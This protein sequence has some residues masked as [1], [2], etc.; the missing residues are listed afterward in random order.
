MKLGQNEAESRRIARFQ[1]LSRGRLAPPLGDAKIGDSLVQLNRPDLLPM[2]G[3]H[4][5]VSLDISDDAAGVVPDLNAPP[6]AGL[7]RRSLRIER[8]Q[9]LLLYLRKNYAR[10]KSVPHSV[11][12]G[13]V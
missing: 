5:A 3:R 12:K 9:P 10:P 11:G 6:V 4:G 13:C 1:R 8:M 7:N 2:R